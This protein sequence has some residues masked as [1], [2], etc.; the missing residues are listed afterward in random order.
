MMK[1]TLVYGPLD[2]RIVDVPKPKAGPREV[3]V[4]IR[5]CLTSGTVIKQ[6]ERPYPGWG[7]PHGLGYEWVGEIIEVGKGINEN[8]IGRKCTNK[9][10]WSFPCDCFFCLRGQP[11]LCVRIK[12]K[13]YGSI[14][15]DD[16]ERG[17][18]RGF[19]KEYAVLPASLVQLIPEHM[20]DEDACQ[21][22]YLTYAVHGIS[23]VSVGVGDTVA[24][25]GA[26]AVGVLLMML[27]HLHGA[28]TVAIDPNQSRLDFAKKLGAADYIIKAANTEEAQEKLTELNINDGYEPDVVIEAVG[29]PETYGEAISLVR[30]GGQVLLFAGCAPGTSINIDTYRLH[31]GEIKIVGSMH[32]SL[33]DYL[34]AYHLIERGAVKPSIFV[35][36]RYPLARVKEALET[37]RR[38][39]G[40]KFAVI[41]CCRVV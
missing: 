1:A 24:V 8:L 29:R 30:R 36:G 25:V 4:K 19:F 41:P 3:L 11:N 32:A 15:V 34:R 33:I 38:G 26:G 37:H 5:M 17:I 22:H 7:Y 9:W 21:I 10:W 27:T 2:V 39:E 35:S 28:Q 6:Y 31:Y 13:G 20:S 40:L 12:N 16:P 23:N 18:V 14:E